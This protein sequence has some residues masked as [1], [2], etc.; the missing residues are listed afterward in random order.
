MET[1]GLLCLGC[2]IHCYAVAVGVL[3][4]RILDLSENHPP[5]PALLHH[6]VLAQHILDDTTFAHRLFAKQHHVHYD[7]HHT[8]CIH[9]SCSVT[10]PC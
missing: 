1:C 9:L 4:R 10:K 5:I 3:F 8:A 6:K 2:A 7:V